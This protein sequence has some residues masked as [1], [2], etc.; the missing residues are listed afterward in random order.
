MIGSERTNLVERSKAATGSGT[1]GSDVAQLGRSNEETPCPNVQLSVKMRRD[2]L[3]GSKRKKHNTTSAE[4]GTSQ[5]YL[6]TDG[7]CG[8]LEW[9][10]EK[11]GRIKIIKNGK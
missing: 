11:G 5:I 2:V 7:E 4:P 10:Q 3:E 9:R 1:E 6:L 8:E